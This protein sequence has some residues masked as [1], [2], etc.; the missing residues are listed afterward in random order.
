MLSVGERHRGKLQK[1]L[2]DFDDG[3]A[4]KQGISYGSS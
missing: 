3:V 1:H 2:R 4:R